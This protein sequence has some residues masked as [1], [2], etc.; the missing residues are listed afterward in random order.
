MTGP[1]FGAPAGALPGAHDSTASGTGLGTGLDEFVLDRKIGQGGMAD[2]WLGHHRRLGLPAAIKVITRGRAHD[3]RYHEGFRREVRAVAGLDHP[4]IVAV[5]DA[6]TVSPEAAAGSAGALTE[7]SPWLAMALAE[8][9]DLRRLPHPMSWPLLREVLL[10]ILDA[11]AHA[12]ARGV[13]HRDLK[14]ENVLL[15]VENDRLRLMLTDFGIAHVIADA[16]TASERA[17]DSVGTPQYMAP[18]QIRGQWRDYG[19]WTDLYALGCV[20]FELATGDPPY[21]GRTPLAIAQAHLTAELPTISPVHPLPAGFAGWVRHL[22]QRDP[23]ARPA[24][25][26]DAARALARLPAPSAE[27]SR[28]A[29]LDALATLGAAGESAPTLLGSPLAL[30]EAETR[31][32][33]DL[34]R[35]RATLATVLSADAAWHLA[36]SEVITARP[37]SGGAPAIT[38]TAP[39][40]EP[41][42]DAAAGAPSPAGPALTDPSPPDDRPVIPATWYQDAPERPILRGLGLGL[43]GVRAVPFVDRDAERDRLWSALRAVE[44]TGKSRLVLVEGTEGS[45]KT[46][47]VEWFGHR[48]AE[49]GVAEVVTLRHSPLEAPGDG[50]A[51]AIEAWF[52]GQGLDAVALERRIADWLASLD[53][54]TPQTAPQTAPPTASQSAPKTAPQASQATSLY[55]EG[56]IEADAPALVRWLRPTTRS[57]CDAPMSP[58]ERYGAAARWLG[59]LT[60]RRAV[61]LHVDDAQWSHDALTFMQWLLAAR[62]PLPILFVATVRTDL[63]ADRPLEAAALDTLRR[64]PRVDQ[65]TLGP[66]PP[67]DHARFVRELLGLDPILTRELLRRTDGNPLFALQIIAEWVE[68]EALAPGPRGYTCNGFALHDIPAHLPALAT[69]RLTRLADRFPE[70]AI[71]TLALETAAALGHAVDPAEWI[72]ATAALDITIPPGL[73]E[74][75]HDA[76]IARPGH[77]GWFFTHGFVRDALLATAKAEGRLPAIH[78]ACAAIITGGRAPDERRAGHLIAAGENHAA[79]DAL[80]IAAERRLDASEYQGT[81]L[82]CDRRAALLDHLHVPENDI[83]R[84]LELPLRFDALRFAGRLPEAEAIIARFDGF[85]LGAGHPRLLADLARARGGLAFSEGRIDAIER[86]YTDAITLYAHLDDARGEVRA[87]HGLGWA[88]LYHGRFDAAERGFDRA[89]ARAEAAG[90]NIELGWALHGIAAARLFSERGNALEP[91]MAAGY[92]FK[93]GGAQTGLGGVRLFMGE[94]ARQ[95]GDREVGLRHVE[96]AVEILDHLGAQLAF[97][98]RSTL[99]F[100]HLDLGHDADAARV[101]AELLAEGAIER[102]QVHYRPSAFAALALLD[103]RAGRHEDFARHFARIPRLDTGF[104]HP[105]ARNLLETLARELEARGELTHAIRAWQITANHWR[106]VNLAR[107][108]AARDRA[109]ALQG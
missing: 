82:L 105:I 91:L 90:I 26:A 56:I 30:G 55:A 83:R 100:H 75:L 33:S 71:V 104:T 1:S 51:A 23:R 9:G 40:A 54:T 4:G 27:I 86:H 45:G 65:I 47:L 5:L 80:L 77:H 57:I 106:P 50:A 97:V 17:G 12:H 48:A 31:D 62:H 53:R 69:R 99:A 87:R 24:T 39:P 101:L 84:A 81:L 67:E 70:P 79:L 74:A 72:A 14:P 2:V 102:I 3:P 28:R 103:L 7:G 29:R 32:V 35:L 25:A 96:A 60:R 94:A 18:E 15:R 22:M 64:L 68:R 43:F 59:G 8:H 63:L 49:L 42:R 52:R 11:L 34:L 46:R 44:E 92:A 108:Q 37:A 41:R 16:L 21:P 78:R 109:D 19:P 95:A 98:A 66:L 20:A 93:K 107:A 88:Q 38:E 6:G 10:Q 85:N 89:R 76:G 13:V 36:A 58:S 73:E 61:V